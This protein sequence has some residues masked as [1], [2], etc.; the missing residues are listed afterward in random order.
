LIC[1]IGYVADVE[2]NSAR[3]RFG[4][5]PESFLAARIGDTLEKWNSPVDELK[6]TEQ[7]GERFYRDVDFAL[8]GLT[9]LQY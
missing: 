6:M 7:E 4:A 1:P 2:L 8:E 5:L 9:H 3:V